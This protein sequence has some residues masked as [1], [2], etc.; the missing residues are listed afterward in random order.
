MAIEQYVPPGSLPLPKTA[1]VLRFIV[2]DSPGQIFDGAYFIGAKHY[3]HAREILLRDGFSIDPMKDMEALYNP[4]IAVPQ[5]ILMDNCLAVLNYQVG[6]WRIRTIHLFEAVKEGR[7]ANLSESLAIKL[8][9]PLDEFKK[10]NSN[11]RYGVINPYGS[12]LRP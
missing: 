1:H 7:K 9:L 8:G 5:G 11:S 12:F 6:N 10:A 2:G 3:E 4:T